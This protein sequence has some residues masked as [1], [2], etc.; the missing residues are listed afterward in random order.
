MILSIFYAVA[1]FSLSGSFCMVSAASIPLLAASDP[2]LWQP[3]RNHTRALND[4]FR[5]PQ[6]FPMRF[7]FERLTWNQPQLS[8][9]GGSC[10]SSRRHIHDTS[11]PV[12][13]LGSSYSNICSVLAI[14]GAYTTPC[15]AQHLQS[16]SC[17]DHLTWW[18]THTEL[19]SM[20]IRGNCVSVADAD[21]DDMGAFRFSSFGFGGIF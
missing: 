1:A 7:E 13:H 16:D 12:H 6:I 20:A 9:P 14:S 21:S 18:W 8:S 5:L 19:P 17:R 3:L 10:W 11:R 4:S 15:S 2:A